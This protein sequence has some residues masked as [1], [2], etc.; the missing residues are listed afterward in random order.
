[1][2]R[3]V[4]MNLAGMSPTDTIET[5]SMAKPCELPVGCCGLVPAVG[6]GK[7]GKVCCSA[8]QA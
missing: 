2:N 1:M 8:T 4:A 5:S 3:F 6:F 7:L